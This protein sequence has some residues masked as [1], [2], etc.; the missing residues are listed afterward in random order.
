MTVEPAERPTS[1]PSDEP[2]EAIVVD[3]VDQKPAPE[4]SAYTTVSPTQRCVGP[5]IGDAWPNET[6]AENIVIRKRIQLFF[7]ILI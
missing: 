6:M 1:I 7:I 5:R 3:P 4:L 2:M